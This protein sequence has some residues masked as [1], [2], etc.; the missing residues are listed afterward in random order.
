[1]W[2]VVTGLAA[3]WRCNHN[4]VNDVIIAARVDPAYRD[5]YHITLRLK[6]H[7]IMPTA[8]TTSITTCIP[9]IIPTPH[10]LNVGCFGINN[11]DKMGTFTTSRIDINIFIFYYYIFKSPILN[12]FFFYFA[13]A[14]WVC[15]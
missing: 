4:D 11:H 3:L 13:L 10:C 2:S 7:P 9:T 6:S 12:I 5:G 14:P 8:P 1:M 15:S